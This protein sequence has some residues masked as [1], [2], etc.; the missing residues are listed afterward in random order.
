M[1]FFYESQAHGSLIIPSVVKLYLSSTPALNDTFTMKFSPVL[2]S[3]ARLSES[4]VGK[5]AVTNSIARLFIISVEP[6]GH[7]KPVSLGEGPLDTGLKIG[8]LFPENVTKVPVTYGSA[9][10][11]Q[12]MNVRNTYHTD[13]GSI[14]VCCFCLV[15]DKLPPVRMATH[16]SLPKQLPCQPFSGSAAYP[17]VP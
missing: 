11:L 16:Y 1:S 8:S 14:L 2:F 5:R 12:L 4:M 7:R 6:V 15:F 17:R 10:N 3:A 9:N 13:F